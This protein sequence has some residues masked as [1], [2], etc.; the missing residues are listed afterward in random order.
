MDGIKSKLRHL[1]PVGL[2]ANRPR[3]DRAADRDRHCVG[4][5]SHP[6]RSH[7]QR[8][9]R[10]WQTVARRHQ[11]PAHAAHRR[12]DRRPRVLL[13]RINAQQAFREDPTADTCDNQPASRR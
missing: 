1:R 4:I 2:R 3:V 13:R 7:L 11:K 12:I 10:A 8:R 6:S 9:I 5:N